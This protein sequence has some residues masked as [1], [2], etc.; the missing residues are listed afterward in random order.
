MPLD[1]TKATATVS[2]TGLALGCYNRITRNWEVALLRHPRHVL[3]IDVTKQTPDGPAKMR[4]QVD[5]NHSIFVDAK[6]A[7]TPSDPLYTNGAE[8]NR[9]AAVDDPEDLRWIVDLEKEFNN[10]EQVVLKRPDFP[11]TP[12]Y[13]SQPVLYANPYI[14]DDTEIVNLEDINDVRPFGQLS[15]GGN[16]D[17]ACRDGGAVILRIVGPL[18][19]DIELTHSGGSTHLIEVDNTC[20]DSPVGTSGGPSSDFK[21]YYSI[22]EDTGREKFDLKVKK[23]NVSGDGAVCNKVFLGA[24][25]QLFPL[26]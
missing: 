20:P 15:E 12:M 1:H 22:V 5:S 2:V 11:V 21:L 13:V 24:R 18:G 10:G 23:G 8:F 19:F 7:I 26:P 6:D 25:D 16:A 14:F 4:F 9:Q 3:N 17:I